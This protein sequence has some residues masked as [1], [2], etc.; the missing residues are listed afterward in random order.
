[1]SK[2]S[3]S[4]GWGFKRAR[5]IFGNALSLL[6]QIFHPVRKGRVMCWAYDFKQYSCNPRYLT[7]H[8]LENN[9]EFEIY[10]VF[11]KNVDTT[12]IDSRINCVRYRSWEYYLLVNTAQFLITNCR[13][14]PYDI[15]W[16]KRARQKYLMLWHGGA[17]LK[18][19]EKDAEDKLSFSYL[20][21]AKLDS[22]ACDLMIS[23]CGVQT[24]LIRSSFWYDGEILEKGIPRNDIFFKKDKHPA[25]K[26][27]I[28]EKYGIH[29]D[30]A[31][32][33][34]A[35]T[36]R[37]NHSL[38][39]YNIIWDDLLP[40]LRNMTGKKNISVLLRLHPNMLR[41]DTSPLLNS[42]AVTDVTKYHDMQ[43]LLCIS[44]LLITDYSSTMFD[45]PMIGGPC[46]LYATDIDEYDRGYYF[47]FYSLPFPIARSQEELV[48]RLKDFDKTVYEAKVKDFFDRNIQLKEDGNAGTAIAAWMR[49]HL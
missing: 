8:L 28:C 44:D 17:A 18:K 25:I 10:W 32:I 41:R 26:K 43:E 19:I 4:L 45:F 37:K 48:Q 49:N 27:K 36:F 7:E 22:K 13:T 1:M 9:P 5:K 24:R 20:H 3:S 33:L 23:G 11:R 47:D 42:T 15:Y 29:E 38:K 30:N 21:K 16:P 31:L 40:D 35:P 39:P 46:I 14:D 6:I 2:L 12:G 34:Y